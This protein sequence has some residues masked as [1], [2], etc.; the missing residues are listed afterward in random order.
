MIEPGFAADE[1]RARPQHSRDLRNRAGQ[2]RHV[3]EDVQAD[4]AIEAAVREPAAARQSPRRRARGP[5][6]AG[7]RSD[8]GDCYDSDE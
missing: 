8:G 7:R 6:Y 4:G 2:I 1:S 3:M 5:R